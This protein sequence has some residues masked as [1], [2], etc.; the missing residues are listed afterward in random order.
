MTILD[1]CEDLGFSKLLENDCLFEIFSNFKFPTVLVNIPKI[2]AKNPF[3]RY[4][5]EGK[6]LR[7]KE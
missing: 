2:P 6:V 5:F 4:L 3:L 1:C 7:K